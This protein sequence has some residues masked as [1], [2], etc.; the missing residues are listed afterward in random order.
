VGAGVAGDHGRMLLELIR[1]RGE[2]AE[3]SDAVLLE[4]G[5]WGEGGGWG[6]RGCEG[7]R[8]FG[9][10]AGFEGNGAHP[11]LPHECKNQNPK[12][13][14]KP[15]TAQAWL[16]WMAATPSSCSARTTPPRSSTWCSQRCGTPCPRWSGCPL[17]PGVLGLVQL[18]RLGQLVWLCWCLD[19]VGAVQ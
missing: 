9:G 13:T 17:T 14:Q 5:G 1:R 16:S 7:G 3:G 4:E 11:S 18:V 15:K 8:G 2:E 12:P 6:F 19:G 10:L